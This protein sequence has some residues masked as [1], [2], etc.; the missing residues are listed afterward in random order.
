MYTHV[1]NRAVSINYIALA[2][3]PLCGLLYFHTQERRWPLFSRC[4]EQGLEFSQELLL[5]SW[6]SG[7]QI[8][9]Q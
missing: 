4:L 8:G 7:N 3:G 2:I 1:S 6:D 9:N 5:P